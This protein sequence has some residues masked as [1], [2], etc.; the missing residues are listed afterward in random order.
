MSNAMNVIPYTDELVTEF[1]DVLE[2]YGYDFTEDGVRTILDTWSKN[3]APLYNIVKNHPLWDESKYMIHF[4]ASIK[5]TCDRKAISNFYDWMRC[6]V[7]EYLVNGHNYEYFFQLYQMSADIKWNIQKI[8]EYGFDVKVGNQN[9]STWNTMCEYYADLLKKFNDNARSEY[10]GRRIDRLLVYIITSNDRFDD[11]L[12]S[13]YLISLYNEF[14][15]R[16]KMRKSFHKGQKTTRA[17]AQVANVLGIDKVHVYK[18]VTHDGQ[19]YEKDFGWNYQF[20]LFADAISPINVKRHTIISINPIDYL[21]MS[22]G[23]GW[24]SCHTIDKKNI[25]KCGDTEHVYEGAYSAGTESYM[26]DGTSMIFYT[27]PM[28]YVGNDFET[29]EKERRC[30]FWY[31]NNTLGESRVYPD[32]RESDGNDLTYGDQFREI[33]QKVIA[34]CL[35]RP[36]LWTVKKGTFGHSVVDRGNHYPDYIHYKDCSI[37]WLKDQN[38]NI[39]RKNVLHIGHDAICPCCGKEHNCSDNIVCDDCREEHATYCAYCGDRIEDDDFIIDEDT[40][41]EYCDSTCANN[42]GVYCCE[43][44]GE[45]HSDCFMDETGNW[46]YDDSNKVTIQN[47]DWCFY[48]SQN[49]IDYGCFID[50][51]DG[52]WYFDDDGNKI[53]TVEGYTYYGEDNAIIDGCFMDSYSHCWYHDRKAQV[54]ICDCSTGEIIREYIDKDNAIA[55]GC[56]YNEVEDKWE[57]A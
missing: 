27:L 28:D 7:P 50:S 2:H 39:D 32:G 3:K 31:E 19:T 53:T 11:T 51:Y 38:G 26:L 30:V 42:D 48:D 33:M 44:D 43:D 52:L 37:S 34:D 4:D 17:I 5:R 6:K 10:D 21:K 13:E 25:D 1:M 18:P 8:N 40:G 36:N 35:D 54:T 47:R 57:V 55:D 41:R 49:A 9:L 12:K 24:R 29:Q 46:Y 22:I 20:S 56:V 14:A 23:R 45:W 15:K 16:Y